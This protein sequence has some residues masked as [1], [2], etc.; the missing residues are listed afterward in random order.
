MTRL[1]ISSSSHKKKQ[2]LHAYHKLTM[3]TLELISVSMTVDLS[4]RVSC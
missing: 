2:L 3:H 4:I 1:V